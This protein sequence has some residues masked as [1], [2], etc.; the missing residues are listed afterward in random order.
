MF[1]TRLTLVGTMVTTPV[2]NHTRKAGVAVANFRIAS[3][4]RTFNRDLGRWVD[5]NTLFL[6]V[7]C[8]RRLAENVADS[9]RRGD[10]VMVTGSLSAQS[11]TAADGTRRWSYEL[12]ASAV[13]PDLTRGTATFVRSAHSSGRF[14]IPDDPD[15]ELVESIECDAAQLGAAALA[16]AG[17]DE[18]DSRHLETAGATA[19][20]DRP[21]PAGA[22]AA[23]PEAA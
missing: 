17:A 5:G 6:K 13:G 1:E 3:T 11:Y 12:E 23:L 21:E 22:P 20:D 4:A 19:P 15:L 18:G 10:P 9:L 8:W 2:L 14:E 16:A 7:A